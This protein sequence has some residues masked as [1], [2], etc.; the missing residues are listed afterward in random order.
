VAA[1]RI[2][3]LWEGQITGKSPATISNI[4]A[5]FEAF[6]KRAAS[7]M[8]SLQT[9]DQL[10]LW[11][12]H[13][14]ANPKLQPRT[15]ANYI[16]Q[17]KTGLR[18]YLGIMLE[19]S[20]LPFIQRALRADPSNQPVRRAMP[21]TR[22]VMKTVTSLLGDEAR[23]IAILAWVTSSR[24][25]DVLALQTDMVTL[26]ETGAQ[27]TR[28]KFTGIKNDKENVLPPWFGQLGQ[29]HELVQGYLRRKGP[30]CPMFTLTAND[31]LRQLK[32][33]DPDLTQHSFKRG[34]AQ[35]IYNE[36]LAHGKSHEEAL[37]TTS[38]ALNHRSTEVTL[39]YLAGMDVEAPQAHSTREAA[40]I[41]SA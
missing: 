39:L 7:M 14:R 9:H 33:V 8:P 28:I 18:V 35:L 24:I 16:S 11:I 40:K 38:H 17:V 30:A 3:K 27:P 6:S 41:L 22:E 29:Y 2:T 21:I 36:C 23:I 26:G 1:E 10:A 34:A 15:L 4:L 25:A 32:T 20:R 37:R 5:R 19:D 13:E 12:G 31:F